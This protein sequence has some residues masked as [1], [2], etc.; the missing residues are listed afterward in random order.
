LNADAAEGEEERVEHVDVGLAG[1]ATA[2][3]HLAQF[4]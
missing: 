3:A 1:V 2:G 4:Q